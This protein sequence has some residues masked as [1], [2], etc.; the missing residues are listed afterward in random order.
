MPS[1][2]LSPGNSGNPLWDANRD[3]LIAA[4]GALPSSDG[5][6]AR[7]ATLFGITDFAT[8]GGTAIAGGACETDPHDI[9]HG[10][11]GPPSPPFEDMGNLGYAARDP[12]FFGHHCNI[13]NLWSGWNAQPGT[14]TSY[15]NPTDPG[16]LNASWSFYDENQ[17]VV[18]ITAADVLNYESNL[19]YTY[20]APRL[21]VT[22]PLYEILV[23]EL[24]CCIPG[25]DPGPYLQVS[26]D[27]SELILAQ[28][29]ENIPVVL[30]LSGVEIP[31]GVTGA[32]DVVAVRGE[33]HTQIG[34]LTVLADSMRAKTRKR[35]TLVL[36]ISK[37]APDLLAHEKPASINLFARHPAENAAK[38][39]ILRAQKAQIRTQKRDQKQR[40]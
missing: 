11:V 7:I 29:R 4:G 14:G 8:F 40:N 17:K 24:V 21:T 39:F 9:I 15:K 5:T 37:A 32:F 3:A 30:V 1:P 2:Y 33:S 26:Q 12:I 13:D 22:I 31:E 38:P 35:V 34:S 19:R 10:D 6:K 27:V 20:Q 28:V 36:D 23:C 25:P 18:S 16:F